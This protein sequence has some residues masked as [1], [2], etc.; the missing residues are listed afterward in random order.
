MLS[1]KYHMS[2][3]I[4]IFL[5]L[6]IGILIGGTIGQQW[7]YQTEDRIVD[8]LMNRY[9]DQLSVNQLLQKQI[10][11][12][13]LMNQSTSVPLLQN[14]KI[15]WVRPEDVHNDLL[16]FVMKSA[17]AEWSEFDAEIIQE[18][19]TQLLAQDVLLISESEFSIP[20]QSSM[21]KIDIVDTRQKWITVQ[22]E[23]LRFNEPK[24]AVNFI[25]YVKRRLEED[26]HAAASVYRYPG[27]E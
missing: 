7:V 20:E 2:T 12:L 8:L 19:T 14:Q 10:S 24:E 21:N 5:A 25:L 23:T 17:G 27:M 6:G 9:E 16:A 15:G 13:Q 1:S 11:S 18:Q 4:A 22:A 3:I 26:T